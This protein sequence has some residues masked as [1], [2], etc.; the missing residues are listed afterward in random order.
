M[1]SFPTSAGNSIANTLVF[2]W[3][4]V[5][6][7]DS[8]YHPS[9]SSRLFTSQKLWHYSDGCARVLCSLASSELRHTDRSEAATPP[10]I[11]NFASSISFTLS[12][13]EGMRRLSNGRGGNAHLLLCPES[14]AGTNARRSLRR[15]ASTKPLPR[16]NRC[17]DHAR[18]GGEPDYQA[19]RAPTESSMISVRY[20]PPFRM[21]GHQP[22][23]SMDGFTEQTD[24]YPKQ[25]QAELDGRIARKSKASK[26][27]KKAHPQKQ[28]QLRKLKNQ[29][30]EDEQNSPAN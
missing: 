11:G 5:R 7:K 2:F 1:Q 27:R 4:T 22:K 3:R 19:R 23:L 10:Q 15:G 25:A 20:T 8:G 14:G 18:R 6:H 21:M 24:Q 28:K 9:S 16:S 26:R 13:Q 12:L 30:K 29:I 17:T